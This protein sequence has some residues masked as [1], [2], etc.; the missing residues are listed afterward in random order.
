[1]SASSASARPAVVILGTVLLN[2]GDA[3]LLAAQRAI[4]EQA[5]GPHDLTVFDYQA[6]R[7]ALRYPELVIRQSF[8]SA[9]GDTRRLRL[10]ALGVRVLRVV[11]GALAMRLGA[12][13]IGMRVAGRHG[14]DLAIYAR[15]DLVMTCGGTFLVPHYRPYARFAD[16]LVVYLLRR[17]LVF[18]TQGFEPARS[19]LDRRLYRAV[20]SRAALVLAR[21]E[22]SGNVAQMLGARIV[23]VAPDAAFALTCLTTP[24]PVLPPRLVAVSVRDWPWVRGGRAT[25]IAYEAAVAALV[26]HVV[27]AGSAVLFISTCQGEPDYPFDDAATAHRVA[28]R[29]T[30]GARSRVEVDQAFHRWDEAQHRFGQ[31]DVVVATRLHAAILAIGAGRPVL[32]IAYEPKTHEV[33]DSLDLGWLVLDMDSLDGETLIAKFE[34]FLS[35]GPEITSALVE[36]L[37]ELHDAAL[38]PARSLRAIVAAARDAT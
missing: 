32:P 28:A 17:P 14:A 22:A 5:L 13:Q 36:R 9:H 20:L 7:S 10:V 35:A 1:M 2:G 18:F 30:P 11:A 15:A 4:I 3:A 6:A 31:A 38:A 34:R 25:S 23:E 24:A 16:H 12:R 33:F 29:L 27:A 21:G 37:P 19:R 8:V 26:E